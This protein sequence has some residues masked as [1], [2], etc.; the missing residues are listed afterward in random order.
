MIWYSRW[1]YSPLNWGCVLLYLRSPKVAVAGYRM[2]YLVFVSVLVCLYSSHGKF[3]LKFSWT[4]YWSHVVRRLSWFFKKSVTRWPQK[5]TCCYEPAGTSH[6]LVLSGKDRR[7]KYIKAIRNFHQSPSSLMCPF[8][9]KKVFRLNMHKS[10]FAYL[11]TMLIH[12]DV[13]WTHI[14]KVIFLFY[15]FV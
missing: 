6:K 2:I 15:F 12:F 11:D 14:N 9:K 10:F 3:V 8:L 7:K 5:L 1:F 13:C 4:K